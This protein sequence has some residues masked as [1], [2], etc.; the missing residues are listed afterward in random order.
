MKTVGEFKE[1]GLVFVDGDKGDHYCVGAA[2][3]FNNGA[4]W[5]G[6]TPKSFAW[7]DNTGVK[8]AFDGLID[9]CYANEGG[10]VEGLPVERLSDS[11][12]KTLY[13]KWR[14]HL[15]KVEDKPKSPY[16]VGAHVSGDKVKPVFTQEMAN[17]GELPPVGS[18]V[19]LNADKAGE[20]DQ[21]SLDEHCVIDCWDKG[22]ILEVIAHTEIADCI[23]PVVK[24]DDSVS[25]IAMEY[26]KP[27][28]TRTPKQ[29][30]VGEMV[31]LIS[32]VLNE[33]GND[34]WVATESIAMALYQDGYR[35]LT[36][37][38]AKAYDDKTEY[39]GEDYK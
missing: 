32:R 12:S 2:Y 18:L 34:D 21:L 7:R 10:I 8:P 9:V 1:A 35:K 22:S 25:A 16:D 20:P 17:A 6:C 27:I 15:P 30:A 28:D 38:Q 36:P 24:F 26:I 23:L 14:P 3:A 4:I 11:N 5:D 39:F 33:S 31:S 37:S 19:L 13:E 29:K